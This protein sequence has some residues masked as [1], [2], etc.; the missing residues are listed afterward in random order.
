MNTDHVPAS[1]TPVR[2]KEDTRLLT[3]RGRYVS[4]LVLPR[5]RH[6]AFVRSP[7][8]HARLAGI[9]TTEALAV[10]GVHAVVT[11][12]H[13]ALASVALR[14]QSALPGYVETDQPPLARGKVRFAGEA[15]AAVVADDRYLAE[16]GAEAVVV[17]YDP[18]GPTVCAWADP[19][20]ITDPVHDEAPDNLL[21]SRTFR[22]GDVEAALAAADVVVDRELTTNRHSGNPIE[23]RAGVAR[24]EAAD[25]RLT[26]WSGTQVPHL[27]RTQLA[28]LLD[29][30]EGNIRV[31]APDVGGGFG[32][33][34]VLY[35]EDVA[36]CLMAIAMPGIPLKWVEDRVE[37]LLAATHARDHRYVLRAGFAADGAL[38][39]VRADVWCNTGA[40]SVYPWTAGIEPLMAGGLLTGPYKLTDYECTVRGVA[41]NTSPSGPYRGVAR[42]ATVFAMEALLDSG[43]RALGMDPIALRR[44]NLILPADVPYRMPSRL[45]DDSGAYEACL[46]RAVEVFDVRRWRAEQIRRRDAGERPIGIGVALYNELTGLGR[47]ASAGPRMPFRTGHDACTV[48]V[49]P[50]GGVTVFSGVTS[51]GQGLETTMAQVVADALGVAYD[52]VD[53]RIGD[54]DE[55]LWGFGAFSSRQAVIGGGAAHLAGG[56]VRDKVLALAGALKEVDVA[57]LDLRAGQVHVRG[58]EKPIISLAEVARVAYLQSDRLPEGFGP[59]LEGTE[60]YDP[61]RGAFAAGAQLA[62]IE[63]DPTTGAVRILDWVCVEDA[64][65]IVHPVIVDG[66]IAGSI[67]QG[68]GGAMYEHLVYD[69]AGNL[70]TG[71]LLDY[72]MPT[73]GEIPELRLDHVSTPAAN[74]TGVRGVGEGG[75]L[76]PAA[77]VAGA[78]GDA[79]G[80]ELDDLPVT[81]AR[82]WELA[83]GRP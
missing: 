53:V 34:A 11:G 74:P 25:R 39:A 26:F 52:A 42:P 27:V 8:A 9:D 40:Y 5:M 1:G 29:L 79:L 60:F 69:E 43:A 36:L 30:P 28:E 49:N 54:T 44:R 62:A 73:S 45:V 71:T 67:A 65:R 81:P 80:V 15:V 24:Y 51:Q 41:T 64:G 63:F 18:L 46:D 12:E 48:R 14:A 21:L 38:L 19:A 2:R 22:A 35:P 83:G 3:G 59:G 66:Q 61:I 23:C 4:D 56:H 17:D 82:V 37:H 75:T 47:A 77:V 57:D 13:P 76:G 55:S 31:V 16:D 10:D 78:L 20:G 68:I 50:D 6:V 7:V 72:L 32:V 33:K 70:S 58:Q